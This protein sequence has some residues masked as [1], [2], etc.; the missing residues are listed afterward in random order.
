MKSFRS[1]GAVDRD[2]KGSAYLPH[3]SIPKP[4]VA[5]GPQYDGQGAGFSTASGSAR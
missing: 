5:S 3:L 4:A 2:G 1:G